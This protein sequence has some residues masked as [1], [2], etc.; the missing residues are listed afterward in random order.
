MSRLK[1]KSDYDD[2]HW[3][4]TGC[5]FEDKCLDCERPVDKCPNESKH[6]FARDR[7][8]RR[9]AEIQARRAEG[10]STEEIC[11]AMGISERTIHRSKGGK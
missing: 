6:L 2:A 10:Q 9:R 4:D 11:K 3:T 5:E 8:Q 1:S 7:K